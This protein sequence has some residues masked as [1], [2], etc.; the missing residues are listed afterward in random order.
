GPG[1]GREDLA[2]LRL[3]LRRVGQD[4]AAYRR[5]LLLEDLDDQ[6]VTKRLQI[7][8]N[9]LEEMF[10]LERTARRPPLA[11]HEEEGKLLGGA[12]L[13]GRRDREA[14]GLG[15]FALFDVDFE[16]AVGVVRPGLDV[17]SPLGQ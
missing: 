17:V 6:A 13:D 15:L 10:R 11:G 7:H 3:L 2:P 8:E 5:L 12:P 4:D 14:A 9:L 1:A 16:H